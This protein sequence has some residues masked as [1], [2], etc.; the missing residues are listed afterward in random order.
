[1]EEGNR[2]G[3]AVVIM[4]TSPDFGPSKRILICLS[5]DVFIACVLVEEVFF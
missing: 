3:L 1:M 5:I 2:K 4:N